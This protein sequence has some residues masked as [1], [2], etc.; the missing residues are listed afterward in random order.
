MIHVFVYIDDEQKYCSLL[1]DIQRFNFLAR[2][3]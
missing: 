2:T 1:A 3:Y